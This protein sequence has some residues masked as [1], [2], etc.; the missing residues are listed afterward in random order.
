MP[1]NNNA[2]EDLRYWM[3]ERERIRVQKEAGEP[4]PWTHDPI[5]QQFKFCN[6]SREHDRVTRW[7]AL[8]WRQPKYWQEKNFVPAI[9]LG[10]TINWPDT[11]EE[12]GFPILWSKERVFECLESRKARG[13]KVYTGAYMVSQYGSRSPKNILVTDNA[14]EYFTRPPHIHYTLEDTFNTLVEYNGVGSFMAGQVLADLKR[15]SILRDAPDWYTWAS[16]GPGSSRGLNRLYDRPINFQPSQEDG[17][18]EMRELASQLKTNLC[19]QDIQNCLCEFDKYM[20][21]KLGQGVP[22]GR[23]DGW[24]KP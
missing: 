7:F 3:S 1:L 24:G 11:L 23:Y 16:L 2:V 10:R 12:L 9:I 6:V 4:K 20:R 17:L 21:T 14:N 13:V 15:T 22:R 5:L 19:L 18:E 8:N